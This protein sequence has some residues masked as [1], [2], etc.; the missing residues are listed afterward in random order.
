M[1]D[2][3]ENKAKKQERIGYPELVALIGENA[4]IS[5]D[6]AKLVVNAAK[7]TIAKLLQEGKSISLPDFGI[8]EVT[9][10]KEKTGRNPKTG[11]KLT[12]KARKQIKFK[13]SSVL[14]KAISDQNKVD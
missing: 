5:N 9:N 7:S 8:F 3:K 13:S 11:E 2:V 12:I 10:R 6:Q 1:A 14:K 4:G